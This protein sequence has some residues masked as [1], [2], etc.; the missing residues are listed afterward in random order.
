MV[1]VDVDGTVY[2]WTHSLSWLAWFEGLWP[3]ALIK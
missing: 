3:L 1:M 2:Q